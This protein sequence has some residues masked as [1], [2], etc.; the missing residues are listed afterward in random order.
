VE[1][2]Y[3]KD[4]LRLAYQLNW[5]LSIC[6]VKELPPSS[7]WL[8]ELKSMTEA[9]GVRIL[10]H[11]VRPGSTHQF[12]LSTLPTVA[13]VAMIRS[14]KGRLQS[15]L[16]TMGCRVLRRNYWLQSVGQANCETLE[17]YVGRQAVRHRMAD[18]RVQC[19]LESL[20]Y[21]DPS[22]DLSEVQTSSYGRYLVNYHFVFENSDRLS[23]IREDAL[24]CTRHMIVRAADKHRHRLA[25]IGLTSNHFHLLLGCGMD[26]D[27]LSIGASYM[28]NLAYAHDSK[29]VLDP[30][31]FV[32]TFGP[33]DRVAIRRYLMG[34]DAP[35]R[36]GA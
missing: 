27:P 18:S 21:H 5:S 8:G 15:L 1:P 32:G 33:Y 14:V 4:E 7:G 13:P 36:P 9:D 20:Q 30:S 17:R 6:A 29:R 10:D 22:I 35:P 24:K 31:F 19:F 34:P 23:D 25:R 26:V 11:H 2:I 12:F 28:N 16:R 3:H